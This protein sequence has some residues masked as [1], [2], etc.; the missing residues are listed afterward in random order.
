MSKKYIVINTDGNN[1]FYDSDVHDNIPDGALEISNTDYQTFFSDS[2]KYYFTNI[3]NKA[4]LSK[5]TYSADEIRQ[6][7]I[8][9]LN[10]EYQPQFNEVQRR[11]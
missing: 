2:G 5:I 6:Q 4:V 8:D 10:T 11:K 7:K 9:A 3:D 1:A